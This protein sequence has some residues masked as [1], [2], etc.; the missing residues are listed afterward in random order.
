MIWGLVIAVVTAA[1]T[2]H[3]V[4]GMLSPTPISWSLRTVRAAIALLTGVAL[5]SLWQFARVALGIGGGRDARFLAYDLA[6]PVIALAV[7]LVIR[8]ARLATDR[9]GSVSHGRIGLPSERSHATWLAATSMLACGTGLVFAAKMATLQP[10]GAWDAWAIWNFK[11][12]WLALGGTPWSEILTNSMFAT[13]HPDYPLLLPL[14]IS[15]LWT[16]GGGVQVAVPQA[17]GVCSGALVGM[18]L[19]GAAWSLRGPTTAAVAGAGLLMLPGFLRASASQLA[20]VPLACCYLATLVALA[21][22]ARGDRGR[23]FVV[24]GLSAGAATWTKNEGLLF[25]VSALSGLLAAAV[26]S[27]NEGPE[28]RRRIGEF[29]IGAAPFL[30]AVIVLRSIAIQSDLIAGQSPIATWQRVTTV[31]R[32]GEILRHGGT[33]LATMPDVIGAIVFAAYLGLT[34]FARDVRSALPVVGT[35]AL[36]ACGYFALYVVTPYELSWHLTTSADRLVVQLWPSAVFAAL[37]LTRTPMARSEERG[38]R[39][40]SGRL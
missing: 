25:F 13:A 23:W 21:L 22:G 30:V 34:G 1:A 33:L 17:F 35:L 2:G 7:V 29:V 40:P 11:A 26:R 38:P 8:R 24:A 9:G 4:L 6:L 10:D 20:D 3:L 28:A 18:L 27:A 31:A 32:Y 16:M 37:L 12:R 5:H 14:S 15:R 39:I 36:T 19:V